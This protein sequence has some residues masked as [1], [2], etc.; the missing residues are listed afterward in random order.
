MFDYEANDESIESPEKCFKI[1]FF[2]C[3]IDQTLNPI[4]ERFESLGT[5]NMTFGFL[6]QS[7]IKHLDDDNLLQSCQD[8]EKFLSHPEK[9]ECDIN[10]LNLYDELK[11]LKV[12]YN[13]DQKT[14]QGILTYLL[15]IPP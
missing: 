10:A 1:I 2:Y 4:K 12:L 6:N 11:S 15:P 8:L 7:F 14:P 5:Y 13:I 9:N 3:I